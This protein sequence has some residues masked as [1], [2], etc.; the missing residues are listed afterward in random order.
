M[1]REAE[2][3]P[4]FGKQMGDPR[5]E[6]YTSPDY[7]KLYGDYANGSHDGLIPK[8][9]SS[10]PVQVLRSELVPQSG[11]GT[12]DEDRSSYRYDPAAL[13]GDQ[14]VPS[15]TEPVGEEHQEVPERGRSGVTKKVVG[16]GGFLAVI[17]GLLLKLPGLAF[18][19]KFAMPTLSALLTV[20]LYS[21]LFGWPFAFGFV[22]SIFIHEMG[23]ALVMKS[24]GIP[25]N[26]MVFVPFLGA[27]VFGRRAANAKDEAEVGIAGPVAGAL[28]AS[29]CLALAYLQPGTLW[30]PLAYLGFFINLFNLIPILPLDGG[31]VLGVV[32][33]RIWIVGFVGLLAF[34]VWMWLQGSYSWWLLLLV[35]MA[36][37]QM[38][39]L[40]LS[41]RTDEERA[42]YNVSVL[43]R[44][45]F[46]LLYFG[47]A[48]VL[49][50][51]MQMSHPLIPTL[52]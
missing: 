19:L 36:A 1:D 27:A 20:V 28:A 11:S 43:T 4:G 46:T 51:G 24:K 44:I 52:Q 13:Y 25:V 47:L 38:R 23:H 42:F 48:A 18:L 5:S 15:S 29:V 33:R 39:N 9:E 21:T 50:M 26:G 2:K 40:S 30:A 12:S 37:L 14:D 8:R 10:Q 49:F 35:V 34:Q 16:A 6:E 7:H 41:P 3:Q 17:G 22:A 32:D 45:V 31:H